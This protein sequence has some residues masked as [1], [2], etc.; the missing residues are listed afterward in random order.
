MAKDKPRLARLTA[1]LTQLQAKQI[2][3]AKEIAERHNVST[4]TVYRDIRTLEQ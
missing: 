2:V 4:R 1:I 3:T